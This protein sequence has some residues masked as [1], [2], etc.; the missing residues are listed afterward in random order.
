M[1]YITLVEGFSV[2]CA[3]LRAVLRKSRHLRV[4]EGGHTGHGGINCVITST[5]LSTRC[6]VPL[7]A[8]STGF[9]PREKAEN[10]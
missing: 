7:Q 3:Y 10:L 2:G 6:K 9:L 8:A 5:T 1:S 4:T